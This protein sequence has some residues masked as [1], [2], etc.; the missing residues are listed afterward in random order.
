MIKLL[1]GQYY[2]SE[3]F[4][5]ESNANTSVFCMIYSVRVQRYAC[6]ACMILM[7]PTFSIS[8]DIRIYNA[9]DQAMPDINS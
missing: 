2:I 5:E 3:P 8:Y 6:K 9:N 4:S 7:L 1:K